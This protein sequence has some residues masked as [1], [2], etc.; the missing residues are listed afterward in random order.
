MLTLKL[1]PL[2]K[3]QWL[4]WLRDPANKQTTKVLS[5]IVG[6]TASEMGYCCLGGLARVCNAPETIL[7]AYTSF[8]SVRYA[9]I[10]VGAWTPGVFE[11]V[12]DVLQQYVPA[13]LFVDNSATNV[14]GYLMH[15]NDSEER[16]FLEIATW[17]EENL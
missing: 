16:S 10:E 2:V 1:P 13:A 6:P 12:R 7:S 15:L 17:I 8:T 3:R 9:L 4:T 11:D 5:R 14:E